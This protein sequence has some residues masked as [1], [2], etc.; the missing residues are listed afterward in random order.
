MMASALASL[1]HLRSFCSSR[2]LFGFRNLKQISRLN[3]SLSGDEAA[4]E[5]EEFD[6]QE[7]QSAL[8]RQK[9]A[10]L[11]QRMKRQMEPAGPPERS[12]TW[13]A[14][15]QIRY[16][17]QESPEEWTVTR[18]AEGFNV[19]TDII[20]RVLRS[21][22][23]P[24]EK[25]KLKQDANAS[26]LLAQIPQG[27]TTDK[28]YPALAAKE[29]PQPLLPSPRNEKLHQSTQNTQLIPA[30]QKTQNAKK[31]TAVMLRAHDALAKKNNQTLH[32]KQNKPGCE[33]H[34]PVLTGN[35]NVKQISDTKEKLI[36]DD[37]WDG[38]VLRDSE[39]EDLSENGLKNTMK[40]V[41]KGREFYDA[42]GNFL[43]R[44]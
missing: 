9:K 41:Q 24:S 21:K 35:S 6:M 32:P 14:I 5:N 8:K 38:E 7:L 44:I 15:E 37:E 13:K 3:S 11:Y 16:L 31:D 10:I 43:Y 4:F 36:T 34:L 22:F 1:F 30:V 19:S 27:V 12:L 40:V 39:L 33:P 23:L 2:L 28:V 29:P 20:K 25:R 26:K 18:L 17:N 42:D